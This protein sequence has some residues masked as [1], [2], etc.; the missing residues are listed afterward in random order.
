MRIGG[1]ER[2][3]WMV[4][5]PIGGLVVLTTVLLGGPDQV[6]SVVEHTL[7]AAWDAAS[8]LLRR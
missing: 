6:L 4:V 7:Y 2:E 5:L 8:L 1:G 3:Q